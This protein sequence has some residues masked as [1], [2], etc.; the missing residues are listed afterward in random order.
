MTIDSLRV[1]LLYRMSENLLNTLHMRGVE[2]EKAPSRL[3]VQ[4][5]VLDVETRVEAGDQPSY[6]VW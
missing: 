6:R 5:W 2:L 3:K 4:R 1:P